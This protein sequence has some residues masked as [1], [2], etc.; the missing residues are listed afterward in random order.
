M[1]F[2]S[3]NRGNGARAAALIAAALAACFSI[4]GCAR[5]VGDLVHRNDTEASVSGSDIP[6]T[7]TSE[8]LELLTGLITTEDALDDIRALGRLAMPTD[9][10]IAIS[11]DDEKMG[12]TTITMEMHLA[13]SASLAKFTDFK[14]SCGSVAIDIS[15]FEIYMGGSALYL[16]ENAM[17]AS[18]ALNSQAGMLAEAA[19][20][21]TGDDRMAELG[22]LN[23]LY[24]S[25]AAE[26]I[27][28]SC[29]GGYIKLT[30]SEASIV[31]V[32]LMTPV[33]STMVSGFFAKDFSSIADAFEDKKDLFCRTENGRHVLEIG[34]DTAGDF[35]DV[36]LGL[37]DSQ[38]LMLAMADS[39]DD[40]LW[41][42]V[43][44]D[45]WAYYAD[46]VQA[47]VD[48]YKSHWRECK[49]AAASGKLDYK[50]RLSF[51]IDSDKDIEIRL[52]M[53]TIID[54]SKAS[55]VIDIRTI[56]SPDDLRLPDGS[57]ILTPEQWDS[58]VR[59][60]ADEIFGKLPGQDGAGADEE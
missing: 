39:Y 41:T 23:A 49:D 1:R 55:R 38:V 4:T 16:S 13:E 56:E 27:E 17:C 14:A 28:K 21:D 45:T 53:N 50:Y 5:Y 24:G 8:P 2:H 11:D 51:D 30:A 57:K 22:E 43:S 26:L 36:L 15:D 9:F 12:S 29:E 42:S 58:R 59:E 25:A 46:A 6:A 18:L 31:P 48:A 32:I 34:S 33:S 19:S 47:R 3:N 40:P 20:G 35:F 60:T 37:D 52:E 54:G 44:E 7:E 10:I